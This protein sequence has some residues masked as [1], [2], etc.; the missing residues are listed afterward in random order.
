M[1]GGRRPGAQHLRA[2]RQV[3]KEHKF[4]TYLYSCVG[5]VRSF[6]TVHNLSLFT[7]RLSSNTELKLSDFQTCL[8]EPCSGYQSATEESNTFILLHRTV[9]FWLCWFSFLQIITET[10]SLYGITKPKPWETNQL[11]L[12]HIF[13]AFSFFAYWFTS[14]TLGASGCSGVGFLL[15]GSCW[16]PRISFGINQVSVYLPL[17]IWHWSCWCDP[18]IIKTEKSHQKGRKWHSKRSSCHWLRLCT[19]YFWNIPRHN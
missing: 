19:L 15:S 5:Y 12:D 16:M 14:L 18:H 8:L 11:F 13:F 3:T 10:A 9:I 7:V 17:S 1:V 6:I 2:W 4:T